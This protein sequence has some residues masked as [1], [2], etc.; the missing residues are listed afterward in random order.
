MLRNKYAKHLSFEA[1]CNTMRKRIGD[2]EDYREIGK[3]ERMTYV[4][5]DLP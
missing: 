2:I 5:L 3:V 4:C 1:L